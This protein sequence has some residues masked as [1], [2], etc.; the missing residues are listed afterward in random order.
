MPK[1]V[2]APP[3]DG[4]DGAVTGGSVAPHWAQKVAVPSFAVP[5]CGQ[6]RVMRAESTAA[7][8][9]SSRSATPS[10]FGLAVGPPLV[11]CT[12]VRVYVLGSGSSGNS[13]LVESGDDRLFIDAG[14]GPKR[15]VEILR[16]L[17]ADLFPKSALGVVVTHDHDD[18]SAKLEPMVRALRA[19][20][21]LHD[22]VPAPRVRQRFEVRR[23]DPT[24]AFQVGRFV[25]RALPLPH[26][27]PQVALRVEAGGTAL[28]WVTDLGHVPPA[29]PGFLEGCHTVFLEANYDLELLMSGP[30]PPR[31][32]DR[33]A[34]PFGHLD[35]R[36]TAKLVERLARL[37][38]ERVILGHLSAVN[39]SP[40]RALGAVLGRA[41]KLEV[42]VVDHGVPVVFDV[43]R[44]A[45]VGVQLALF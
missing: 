5:H 15:S 42:R 18:H 24:G 30:Y 10:D 19:P 22:G 4:A 25:V 7:A 3:L 29:L 36:D 41:P 8:W 11:D 26:D 32:R 1:T 44:A 23:F 28:G 9:N 6:L 16:T 37:G 40:E 20:A 14:I 21:F 27:A 38:V 12:S 43:P 45:R 31:L 2:R 39:N 13:A 33:V 35:N 34:G 17:G